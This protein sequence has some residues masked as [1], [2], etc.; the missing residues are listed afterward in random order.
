MHNKYGDS[1]DEDSFGEMINEDM[2]FMDILEE[3]EKVNLPQSARRQIQK[4]IGVLHWNSR[5][6][7][8][9]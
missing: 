3:L 7:L 5:D 1:S 8:P 4:N 6:T 9:G 2:F